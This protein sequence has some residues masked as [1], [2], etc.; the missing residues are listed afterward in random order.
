MAVISK[1]N[2]RGCTLRYLCSKESNIASLATSRQPATT[3]H[4]S[5]FFPLPWQHPN[6]DSFHSLF[7]FVN[8]FLFVVFNSRQKLYVSVRVPEEMSRPDAVANTPS[9]PQ[10][11]V[12]T[13]KSKCFWY[14]LSTTSKRSQYTTVF[15]C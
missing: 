13:L 14:T 2:L 12:L 3:P 10:L 4:T 1:Y 15:R 9:P 8:L 11:S 5:R 7:L 6:K